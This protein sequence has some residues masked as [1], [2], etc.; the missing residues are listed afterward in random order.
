MIK[1]ETTGIQSFMRRLNAAR[2]AARDTDAGLEVTGTRGTAYGRKKSTEAQTPTLSALTRANERSEGM[3]QQYRS[4]A[5]NMRIWNRHKKNDRNP[6]KYNV[7]RGRREWVKGAKR[8]VRFGTAAI[9]AAGEKVAKYML[10]AV[11]ANIEAGNG[12]KPNSGRYAEWKRKRFPGKP[13]LVLSGQL[14]ESLKPK[15]IQDGRR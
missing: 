15:V 12:I 5:A 4:P 11:R 2:K 13:A 9:H 7:S 10:D 6:F 3:R 14:L 8:A 1:A